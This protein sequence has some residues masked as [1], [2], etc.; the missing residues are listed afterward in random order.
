MKTS[1]IVTVMR[2]VLAVTHPIDPAGAHLHLWVTNN[3][4][5]D[6][7]DVMRSLGFR[8]ITM[9]TWAKNRIGLGQYWRGQTEH[10]LFGVMGR[11]LSMARTEST[12]VG[13]GIVKRTRHSE[14]PDVFFDEVERVS[15]GP[16]L[17]LF[18]RRPRDGWTVWG[19]EV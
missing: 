11:L 10:A 15:P 3:H 2:E 6:G 16:R 17:E 9:R 18:A 12:L 19:N 7:L 14:K 8:Y 5:S 1:E 4:L 13:K